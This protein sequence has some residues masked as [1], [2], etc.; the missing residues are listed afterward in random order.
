MHWMLRVSTLLNGINNDKNLIKNLQDFP[1]I[2][3]F[4][5][6]DVKCKF[7]C[8]FALKQD[9]RIEALQFS[10]QGF[11]WCNEHF[12][13]NKSHKNTRTK[14]NGNSERWKCVWRIIANSCDAN[15]PEIKRLMMMQHW[16]DPFIKNSFS[17]D[18]WAF[19][20]RLAVWILVFNDVRWR[21][22]PWTV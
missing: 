17:L 10:Q 11:R 4:S 7:P 5:Q 6:L 2:F 3:L 22:L 20:A 12:G 19:K 1:T 14:R 8:L 18:K 16:N 9:F 21:Q 13:H 15:K